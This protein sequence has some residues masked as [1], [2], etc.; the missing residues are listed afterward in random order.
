MCAEYFNNKVYN[1]VPISKQYVKA[2]MQFQ[3]GTFLAHYGFNERRTVNTFS[4]SEIVSHTTSGNPVVLYIKGRWVGSNGRVI[5][6][7]DNGHFLVI[8]GY[9][10]VGFYFH[11]PGSRDNTYAGAIP[12]EDFA[13]VTIKGVR[14]LNSSNPDFTPRYKVNTLQE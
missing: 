8:T 10:E 2:D 12:F 7:S 5:H 14:Y 3:T 1:I 9:D 4:T 11:D 13:N 6:K